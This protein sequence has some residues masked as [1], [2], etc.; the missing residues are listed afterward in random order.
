MIRRNGFYECCKL[1]SPGILQRFLGKRLGSEIA[2]VHEAGRLIGYTQHSGIMPMLDF[3]GSLDFDCLFFPDIFLQEADG[4]KIH[5]KLG[6][7]MA[8]WTG[9]SDTIHMPWDDPETVRESVRSVFDIFGPL[10]LVITPCSGGRAVFPW[11][12]VL[13]MIDEWRALRAGRP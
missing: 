9:P 4:A 7:K 13:A 10:G 5:E 1:F 8:F 11:Q 3:L 6:R 2:V 12:N